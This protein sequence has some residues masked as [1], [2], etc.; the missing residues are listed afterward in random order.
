[1]S[2]IKNQAVTGFTFSLTNKTDGSAVTTGT[3]TGYVTLD[4]GTQT[5]IAGSPVHE[6]NGQ[7][8]VNLTA[9]EMN[10]DVVG[11]I[12]VNSSAFTESFTINTITIAE[13]ASASISA[14]V[15][16]YKSYAGISVSTWDTQLGIIM[17]AVLDAVQDAT[18]RVLTQATFTEYLDGIGSDVLIVKNPPISSITSIKVLQYPGDNPTA[19]DSGNYTFDSDRDTGIIRLEPSSTRRFPYDSFGMPNIGGPQ[20]GIYPNWPRGYRN[21]KVV[22]VGGYTTFPARLTMLLYKITDI[23]FAQIR[24]DTTLQSEN[25]GSYSYT[26]MM[27]SPQIGLLIKQMSQVFKSTPL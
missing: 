22:Y 2:F 15:T 10:G 17:T 9:A 7:W 23:L 11:L 4:G 18:G 14:S 27:N 20:Y 24:Q 26:R 13:A 25:L 5:A 16:G 12:F 8:S 21:I 6:G 1:M 19:V 3:T